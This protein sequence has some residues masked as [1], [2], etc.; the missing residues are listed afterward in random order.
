MDSHDGRF[1]VKR[2]QYL[3]ISDPADRRQKFHTVRRLKALDEV[4]H[5]FDVVN[6]SWMV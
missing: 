5:S 4:M 6:G 3:L 1:L 2:W